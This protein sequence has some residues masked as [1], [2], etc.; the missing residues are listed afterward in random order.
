MQRY[1]ENTTPNPMFVGNAMI[2]PGE[3]RMVEVADVAQQAAAPAAGPSIDE[4]ATELLKGT[5]AKISAALAELTHEALDRLELLEA[6][7]ANRTT[8]L[9]AIGAEKLQ[10]SNAAMEKQHADERATQL[11][12]ASADL[13]AAQAALDVEGDTDKHP[14]LEL[15]VSEAK[16]RVAALTDP[17][18]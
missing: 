3:G 17:A 12:Q 2:P 10:R 16:A 7:G 6:E 9:A 5:V 11:A 4:L 8:L 13:E 14:A 1:V 15:A 18:A